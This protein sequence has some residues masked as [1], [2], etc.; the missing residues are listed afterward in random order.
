ME[1]E[2]TD[3]KGLTIHK[4]LKNEEKKLSFLSLKSWISQRQ[5]VGENTCKSYT[6]KALLSEIYEELQQRKTGTQLK[7]ITQNNPNFKNEQM[8]LRDVSSR[9]IYKWPTGTWKVLNIT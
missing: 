5:S 2:T 8:K 4:L 1:N 7:I 9:K 3:I 6:K